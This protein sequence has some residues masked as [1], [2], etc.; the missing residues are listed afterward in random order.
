LPKIRNIRQ[1]DRR[2]DQKKTKLPSFPISLSHRSGE[3][4]CESLPD[5]PPAKAGGR[6]RFSDLIGDFRILPA[7]FV[8]RVHRQ[9]ADGLLH[10]R[11]FFP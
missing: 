7:A 10:Q 3:I 11:S 8:R 9:M 1:I 5:P 4:N 6:K 2:A